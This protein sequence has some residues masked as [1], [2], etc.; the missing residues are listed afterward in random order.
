M[1]PPIRIHT[2]SADD[3]E[4][5]AG[6]RRSTAGR[7]YCG[8]DAAAETQEKGR[9][10]VEQGGIGR[11]AW[12]RRGDGGGS[13]DAGGEA[14]TNPEAEAKGD[15]VG[16]CGD[17]GALRRWTPHWTSSS[18][19]GALEGLAAGARCLCPSPAGAPAIL[20]E[21]DGTGSAPLP[22][23]IG[24]TLGISI[25]NS[26]RLHVCEPSSRNQPRHTITN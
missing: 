13:C 6:V 14:G 9:A 5:V 16:E 20:R 19:I 22:P 2:W 23:C 24:V 21:P 8:R 12:W 25:Q 7:R 3:G 15:S 1:D 26:K 10:A 4:E 18:P 11:R 17:R